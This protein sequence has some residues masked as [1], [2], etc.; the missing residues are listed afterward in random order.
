MQIE[1]RY[2]GSFS[3]PLSSILHNPPKLEA[4]FKIE[5]PLALFN[6]VILKNNIFLLTAEEMIQ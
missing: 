2:L 1:Y 5:R 4:M 3:I 6:Y